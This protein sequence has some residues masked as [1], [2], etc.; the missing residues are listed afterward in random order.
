MCGIAG[1][2][3][4]DGTGV[5]PTTLRVMAE[6]L[7]HRGPDDEGYLLA[8]P[9]GDWAIFGGEDTPSKVFQE[10]ILYAPKRKLSGT[11]DESH[12]YNIGLANRRL[13]IID[14]SPAGHQPICNE[15]GTTW[16]VHNGEIYNYAILR[17]G[18]LERGHRFVSNS[19]TEV[20]VHAYEEWGEDCVKHFD[21]MWAFAIWDSKQGRLFCSRDRFGIKPFYYYFDGNRFLF[22]SETKALLAAG[23]SREVDEASVYLYI[24]FGVV[25]LGD[26]TFFSAIRR[27][28]AGHNLTVDLRSRELRQK[29]YW[30]LIST[31][32][33]RSE[34]RAK[35]EFRELFFDAVKLRLISDVPVGFCLSGGLDSSAIVCTATELMKEE[36]TGSAISRIK[37]F[38]AR[39]DDPSVDEGHYIDSVIKATGVD[40]HVCKPSGKDLLEELNQVIYFQ[41]E[42]FG[43][44]SIYAG[45]SVMSLVAR[46][47]IKVVLDG[48]GADEQ[49]VGYQFDLGAYFASLLRSFHLV[50]LAR[51]IT[52]LKRIQ[53]GSMRQLAK[54][55]IYYT[56]PKW[57]QSWAREMLG[58]SGRGW[59]Q[60]GWAR[61]VRTEAIYRLKGQRVPFKNAFDRYRYSGIFVYPLPSLLRFEDRN[62]MAH[63]VEAR[64]PFLDHRLIEFLW[65]LPPEMLVRNGVRKWVLREAMDG[66]LPKEV[67]NRHWKLG[68][69][70]PQSVWFKDPMKELILNTLCQ[71]KLAANG[72][73]DGKKVCAEAKAFCNGQGSVSS[74]KIWRW[75]NLE[76]WMRKLLNKG[77]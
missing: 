4:L 8:S 76:L 54:W 6:M 49:L 66:I 39:Y 5:Q 16:V 32:K 14:L 7:R 35:E 43:S 34:E 67:Q 17:E 1:I 71:P 74:D 29:R 27:L 41:D 46:E 55:V 50:S 56:L 68:F 38:S 20:I 69:A 60:Q 19:D 58:Q 51:Q 30:D 3:H 21:G 31:R 12:D 23:V 48:Q 26:K 37:T 10:D 13:S 64:V 45:W 63:S 33:W 36:G 47:K 77:G 44:T 53:H 2:I 15:D 24:S 62:A 42:P 22:A 9:G 61:S 72:F 57:A 70:T 52:G 18:L 73:L 25:D 40:A 59:V 65:S 75:L 28:D 11:L